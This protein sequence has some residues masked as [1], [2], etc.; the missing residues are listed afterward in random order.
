MKEKNID[1]SQ[2]GTAPVGKL[3]FRM[4]LPAVLSQLVVLANNFLD[5][6]Y[7]GHIDGCGGAAL[8]AI[9]VSTPVFL[10]SAALA[11]LISGGA[12]I[13]SICL[14][15]KE[16]EKAHRLVETTLAVL[17]A[18]SLLLTILIFA[19]SKSLLVISGASMAIMTYANGYLRIIAL[20]IVPTNIVIGMFQF[21]CGEGLTQKVM[22]IM[23]IA[24]VLNLTLDP[25][26]IF[27]FGWGL[28]GAAWATT[29]SVIFPAI[30]VLRQLTAK[31]NAISVRLRHLIPDWRLFGSC[32]AMGMSTFLAM[33]CEACSG[34]FYN[35]SLLQYGGDT[36]VG[37]MAIYYIIIQIF[38]YIILGL[39][40]GM[41]P[42]IS[43]S[44]GQ[45]NYARVIRCVRILM[46]SCLVVSVAVWAMLML[47][48]N[49][50]AGI[51]TEDA[52]MASYAANYMRTYFSCVCVVGI[53]YAGINTQRF[54]NK[55]GNSIMLV[56]F[57]RLVLT[58]P[59]L[60]TVPHLG[61]SDPITSIYLTGPVIDTVSAVVVLY[62]TLRTVNKL[63][64]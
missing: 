5:R 22:K 56:V 61:I 32:C 31:S 2:F 35:N 15:K 10:V 29:I 23:T 40:L 20:G 33:G 26:F 52:G 45:Q 14:G 24:V 46:L 18:V 16:N 47:M 58:L 51:F 60:L 39:S 30:M 57:R 7:V 1:I 59:L 43:Y 3:F 27:A 19:F 42:I 50:I 64:Q 13:M 53:T 9:G 25:L 34:I 4:A 49:A 37:A 41:Q 17:V 11:S 48:P 6:M 55:V 44:F 54:L 28:K 8:T 12:P 21:L 63:K 38:I 36:A 62:V